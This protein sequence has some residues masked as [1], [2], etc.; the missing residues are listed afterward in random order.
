[1]K[2][3]QAAAGKHD[4]GILSHL[5]R[6]DAVCDADVMGG[7]DCDRPK[8]IERRH[9]A[10][11]RHGGAEAQMALLGDGAVGDDGNPT[12]RGIQ[13]RRGLPAFV[14]QL[15]LAGLAEGGADGQGN[16]RLCQLVDNQCAVRDVFQC[17]LHAELPRDAGGGE[18]VVGLARGP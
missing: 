9:A 16:T 12:S 14:L 3:E 2:L 15:D 11:N 6:T 4:V 5:N 8:R 1:M 13:N 17:E 7:V 10:L 18:D